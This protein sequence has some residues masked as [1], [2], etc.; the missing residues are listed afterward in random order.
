MNKQ[1]NFDFLR[2]LFALLVIITHSYPLSGNSGHDWLGSISDGQIKFSMLGVRGFFIISGFLIFQSMQRSTDL[3]DYFWKRFLRL[4]PALFTV[5]VLTVL[6]APFVYD[7]SYIPYTQNKSVL[8]YI[9]RNLGLFSLQFNIDG[10]FEKLPYPS[11]INGSLWTIPYEFIMYFVISLLFFVRNNKL[12]LRILTVTVFTTFVVLNYLQLESVNN[13]KFLVNGFDLIDLGAAFF[14]GSVLALMDFTVLKNKNYI[15]IGATSLFVLSVILKF[16]SFTSNIFF[17]IA[18]ILFGLSSTRYINQI[19]AKIGDISYGVYIYGFPV[20]QALIYFYSYSYIELML[21]SI[22]IS[23]ILGF[24]SWHLVEKHALKHKNLIKDRFFDLEDKYVFF[25]RINTNFATVLILGAS[26]ICGQKVLIAATNNQYEVTGNEV[27]S[28]ELTII[29]SGRVENNLWIVCAGHKTSTLISVNGIVSPATY[30]SDHLT[31]EIPE[32]ER[33]SK[34]LRLKLTNALQNIKS[35]EAILGEKVI[36]ELS[37]QIEITQFGRNE[38][39][40]VWIICT[41]HTPTTQIHA[42][43]NALETTYYSDHLTAQLS[44]SMTDSVTVQLID[45]ISKNESETV[46]IK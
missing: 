8:S 13:M 2:L 7:N 28:S 38:N 36:A 17:P 10:V 12:L 1:N 14:S 34:T 21:P 4:F 18:V 5:L 24:M 25:K 11:A 27:E 29:N 33:A 9:P 42:N 22:L 39:N 40:A 30:Y 35:K 37:S 15:L 43:G 31:C 44:S 45:S 6:L 3:L 23:V 26:I 32:S 46:I 19:G 41:G 16:Y 20:Q